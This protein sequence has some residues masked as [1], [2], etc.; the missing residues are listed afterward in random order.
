MKKKAISYHGG[1]A[2]LAKTII[3]K[4]PSHTHYVEPYFGGGAVFFE[5]RYD[6]VSEVINDIDGIVTNFWQILQDPY[7]F[8]VFKRKVEAI[9]FSEVEWNKA[10]KF[11]DNHRTDKKSI[12]TY[13]INLAV[14]FFVLCRQSRQGLMKNFS[15]LCQSRTRRGMQ[16]KVSSWISSIECLDGVHDR[17]K[18]VVIYNKNALDVIRQQD[19]KQTFFYLDP[20]YIKSTR[21]AKDAYSFEM[22]DEDHRELLELISTI[23]GRFILSGYNNSLYEEYALRNGWKQ[24]VIKIDNK[25]SSKKTKEIK[26]EYLWS[27]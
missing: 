12:F 21:I 26:E 8:K 25:A 20:P 9:P 3:E 13:N 27:N 22:T 10:K 2:Y 5:K 7:D 17:L 4:F 14:N 11:I 1:K 15:T 23:E 19:H 24:D 6:N 18:G 16:E